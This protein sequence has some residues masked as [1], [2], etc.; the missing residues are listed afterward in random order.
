MRYIY[1]VTRDNALVMLGSAAESHNHVRL[2]FLDGALARF[3]SELRSFALLASHSL[4][5]WPEVPSVAGMRT[6]VR[7][8]ANPLRKKKDHRLLVWQGW[9]FLGLGLAILRPQVAPEELVRYEP[10]QDGFLTCLRDDEGNIVEP[11]KTYA[12][13]AAESPAIAD[14]ATPMRRSAVPKETI[15]TYGP[16]R[17]PVK[18][19]AVG[20]GGLQFNEDGMAWDAEHCP[21]RA[22]SVWITGPNG[23]G[24][25]LNAGEWKP[26]RRAR[27]LE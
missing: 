14:A 26:A 15:A 10:E 21:A 13:L 8:W 17:G 23:V 2:K 18:I 25:R 27:V 11:A 12:E 22:G 5:C 16:S 1:G 4:P 24:Y 20:K 9:P 7:I 3:D 19:V 6:E